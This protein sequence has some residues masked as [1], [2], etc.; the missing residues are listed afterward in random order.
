MSIVEETIQLL[1]YTLS[2]LLLISILEMIVTVAECIFEFAQ[3][4]LS[5]MLFYKAVC[6]LPHQ[7]VESIPSPP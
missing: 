6:T 2:P 1:L 3:H 5:L 7:E 4:P